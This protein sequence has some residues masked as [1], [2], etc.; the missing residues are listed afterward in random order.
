MFVIFY[1]INLY[2]CVFMTCSTSYCLQ[3]KLVDP[4]N[5]LHV[6]VHVCVHVRVCI[7][8]SGMTL[9][10]IFIRQWTVPEQTLFCQLC[11]HAVCQ[12]M[13]S[14]TFSRLAGFLMICYLLQ[15]YVVSDINQKCSKW[16]LFLVSLKTMSWHWSEIPK[17]V[18]RYRIYRQNMLEAT[19]ATSLIYMR[20][21]VL[22]SIRN[23]THNI[24][25][26]F[27]CDDCVR[28]SGCKVHCHWLR[29]CSNM[30]RHTGKSHYIV[31]Q[32]ITEMNSVQILPH[33]ALY[34]HIMTCKHNFPVHW[35][36]LLNQRP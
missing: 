22:F 31:M 33:Y 16:K 12:G 20:C 10:V 3:H 11:S 29:T 30:S 13:K 26:P 34:I 27:I 17:S 21:S 7:I 6:R 2:V 28:L 9:A 18:L 35:L 32:A 23:V 15:N 5:T 8:D 25:L 14:C 4:W 19:E 24:T 36:L 1:T